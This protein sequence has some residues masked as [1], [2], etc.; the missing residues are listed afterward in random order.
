MRIVVSAEGEGLD[1]RASHVFGR[2]P[3]Y[4]FVETDSMES[5]TMNNPAIDE[6]SGA[7]IQAAQF[8]VEQGA[9]AVITGNVGPNAY[10]VLQASGTPVYLLE[11]GTVREV[12]EAY[13][14]GQLRRAGGA[15]GPAHAGL[16]RGIGR[17]GGGRGLGTRRSPSSSGRQPQAPTGG[18]GEKEISE[19]KKLVGDLRK[20]LADVMD[21]LDEFEKEE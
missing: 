17:G 12:L 3:T 18:S 20:Q 14:R 11:G 1:A 7:G 16:G 13:D 4:V 2:C 10:N 19:L 9:E 8:V 21:R 15:T 5:E 6:A